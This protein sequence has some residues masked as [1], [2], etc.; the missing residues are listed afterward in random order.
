MLP[1]KLKFSDKMV[2]HFNKVYLLSRDPRFESH[3]YPLLIFVYIFMCLT[4]EKVFIASE[5]ILEILSSKQKA[6]LSNNLK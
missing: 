4:Q 2:S 6:I 5:G 3:C 1:L